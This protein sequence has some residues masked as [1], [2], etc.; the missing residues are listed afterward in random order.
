MRTPIAALL[1]ILSAAAH[2]DTSEAIDAKAEA[3]RAAWRINPPRVV[4][5]KL[6]LYERLLSFDMLPG[7]VPVY[8][9]VNGD[10]YSM[11]FVPDGE[12]AENWT[13][14]VSVTGNRNGTD[15]TLDHIT[16]ASRTFDTLTGCETGL[17]FR[18]LGQRAV[19]DGLSAVIV[20]RSC[21]VVSPS[22]FFRG[23]PVGEQNLI[24]H[25]R[26]ARD[27]YTLQFAV[28]GH[29]DRGKRPFSDD[30]V[31]P[32]LARLGSIRLC[33]DGQ[34]CEGALKLP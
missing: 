33:A 28:R 7:F 32:M 4:E 23:K 2:A 15:E 19:H 21:A 29:Y 18:E 17:Y 34:P 13:S 16:Q 24:L 8:E 26:D 22:A 30:Q 9:N 5:M 3:M 14:K 1:L 31:V 25:F 11:D 6:P 12:T 27:T 20:N 10:F